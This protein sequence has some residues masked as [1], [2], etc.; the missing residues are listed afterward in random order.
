MGH[1]SKVLL[2]RSEVA[3]F[4]LWNKLLKSQPQFYFYQQVR[5]MGRWRCVVRYLTC[6]NNWRLCASHRVRVWY[7]RSE[8]ATEMGRRVYIVVRIWLTEMNGCATGDF[9][10]SYRDELH[11][12]WGRRSKTITNNITQTTRPISCLGSAIGKGFH[13]H[14][15]FSPTTRLKRE[16]FLQMSLQEICNT[17]KFASFELE[18]KWINFLYLVLVK[19]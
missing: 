5:T 10:Q 8:V 19:T 1:L 4:I 16:L 3:L 2:T 6:R 12:A 9:Q 7:L 18:V 15:L 11:I 17:L 14:F 13:T